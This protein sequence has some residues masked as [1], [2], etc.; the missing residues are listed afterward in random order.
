MEV[1][2]HCTFHQRQ[3]LHLVVGLELFR[4]HSYKYEV[5]KHRFLIRT[6]ILKIHF[7]KGLKFTFAFWRFTLFHIF[8]SKNTNST[9]RDKTFGGISHIIYFH[10]L[11]TIAHI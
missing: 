4:K 5:T 10:R 11:I 8:Y 9:H 2:K 1:E 7:L 3:K 6:M